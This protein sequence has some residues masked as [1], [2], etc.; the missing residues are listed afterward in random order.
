VRSIRAGSSCAEADA[1]RGNLAR[2]RQPG[3]ATDVVHPVVIRNLG[4]A[5]APYAKPGFTLRFDGWT[6]EESR[7]LLDYLYR[8]AVRPEFTIRFHWRDGSLAFCDNSTRWP[9]SS[10]E[11]VRRSALLG[12]RGKLF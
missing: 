10:S 1:R 2:H 8:H 7:P 9:T 5:Q 4:S 3:V 6:D 12:E 11:P